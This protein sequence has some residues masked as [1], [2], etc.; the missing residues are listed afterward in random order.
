MPVEDP[1]FVPLTA[2]DLQ[3]PNRVWMAPLTR[4][5]SREPGEV[6]T[7]LM[8]AYYRQRA[9]AGLIIAE[10]TQ[11]SPIGRGYYG[12]PGIHSDEQVAGWQKVTAA[13]HDAGGLIV[14]QLWH[15]GRV[16]H[17][18]L[19]PGG[20]PPVAP[21]AQRADAKTY[22]DKSMERVPTSM[23][24]AME[25]DEI[26]ATVADYKQAAENARAAGFDGVE[27]HGANGYLLD[28]FIRTGTNKRTDRYGGSLE[29]R[30]RFPLEATDA[31]LQVWDAGRVGYR[32]NPNGSGDLVDDDPAETFA[33]LAEELGRRKLAYLHCVEAFRA[34]RSP[35]VLPVIAAARDA[36]RAAGGG[37]YVGNGGYTA[38]AAR[39]GLR[40]GTLD[41]VA[42]GKLFISNPDLPQRLRKD[43]P[44]ADF[45][46]DT[47]Y[48]GDETGYTD[49][50][51]LEPTA[52]PV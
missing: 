49:Y 2:G 28:E 22:I 42:W 1:L 43:A 39:A 19:Q 35:A 51:T 14:L 45:D 11:I 23:P 16:S 50:P 25:A 31:V 8:A 44:L 32:I 4:S 21:S 30:L 6:P 15:V 26:V 13:V 48:G 5:R 12:T 24:R 17:T 3:T 34:E 41:A 38:D 18:S 46:S 20:R 33:A 27:I 47:F 10:A 37:A 52:S 29:N 40:D 7:D 36:F 9:A